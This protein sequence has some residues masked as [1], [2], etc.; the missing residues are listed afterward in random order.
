MVF[1]SLQETQMS[2]DYR[3]IPAIPFA[4]LF[5]G[6]LDKYGVREKA[7][8]DSTLRKRYLLGS[9]GVLEAYQNDDGTSSFSRRSFTPVPRTVI[10]ALT[11]EFGIELVSE[12]DHR[13]WGF[14]NEKDWTDWQA[15][16]AKEDEDNFY[17][18]LCHYVRGEPNDL[19]PGTVG[20]KKAEIAKALVASDESLMAPTNRHLLLEAVEAI[21]DRDHTVRVTVT[22]KDLA[23]VELTVAAVVELMLARTDKLPQA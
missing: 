20:L 2:T 8:A 7:H 14:A 22:N 11:E 23:A 12:H 18:D 9:D 6:R 16:L 13:Y 3:P 17:K 21:Y 4:E 1:A 19:R 10:D 15:Q 5:D